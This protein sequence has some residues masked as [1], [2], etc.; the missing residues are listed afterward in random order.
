[1]NSVLQMNDGENKD[2]ML[3]SLRYLEGKKMEVKPIHDLYY[4]I[5]PFDYVLITLKSLHQN[6][7]LLA[8]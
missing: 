1:M 3:V 6:C 8:K 5:I 4:Q 2:H 7:Q